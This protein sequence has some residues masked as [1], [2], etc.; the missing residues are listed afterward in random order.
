MSDTAELLVFATPRPDQPD[1]VLSHGSY[2]TED[3]RVFWRGSEAEEVLR[4][5]LTQTVATR[6]VRRFP[7]LPEQRLGERALALAVRLVGES[8]L[9]DLDDLDDEALDEALSAALHRGDSRTATQVGALIAGRR[10]PSQVYD[11]VSRCLSALGAAWSDGGGTVLAERAATDAARS[12]VTQLSA[13]ASA[14]T[15]RGR[16]VLATP[17][18]DRHTLGLAALA[19]LLQDAG[20]PVLV[21][22]DL[23]GAELA[24]LA[25]E[26]TTAAIVIS[27]HNSLSPLAA[28]RLLAPLRASSPHVLLVGGGVGFPTS[29]TG[30]D[31]CTSDVGV[32]DAA[33]KEHSSGLTARE[34]EVLLGIADGCTNAQLAIRLQVSVATV[35]THL[36]HVFAKTHAPSR[37]AAVAMAL[38]EGWIR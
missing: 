31:L 36:D 10:G 18:G 3:E 16:V 11:V 35:K 27:A 30:A 24:G 6:E 32:L 38:R 12:V 1:V 7:D 28:R 20:H 5:K 2:L 26:A 17:P 15:L 9:D 37:A 34:R 19:H 33:L 22:D 13:H 21:V 8:I 4:L 25:A 29:S 23:P 14:P